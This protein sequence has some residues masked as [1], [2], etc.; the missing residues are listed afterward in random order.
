MA[1]YSRPT[2]PTQRPTAHC[3]PARSRRRP[4][5][6]CTRVP[7]RRASRACSAHSRHGHFCGVGPVR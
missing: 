1:R 4:C 3:A 6:A 5:Y 7:G 2:V